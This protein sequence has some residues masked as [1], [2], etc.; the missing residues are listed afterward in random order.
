LAPAG[1]KQ[2][3]PGLWYPSDV[4][5]QQYNVTPP[6]DPVKYPLDMSTIEQKGPA[7]LGPDGTT[8]LAPGYF[9]PTPNTLNPEPPWSPPQRLIDIRDIIEVPKGTL[10]PWGYIEYLPGWWAPD[11]SR[12]GPR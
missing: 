5:R 12:G 8:E 4:G 9:A 10:A 11:P 7:Q 2:I 3:G 1:Y 6:P